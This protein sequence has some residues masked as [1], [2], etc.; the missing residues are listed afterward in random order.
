MFC[1]H[2]N[3]IKLFILQSKSIW[4]S[5]DMCLHCYIKNNNWNIIKLLFYYFDLFECIYCTRHLNIYL[6]FDSLKGKDI[7]FLTPNR[8]F[9]NIQFIPDVK[10]KNF[11]C[12]SILS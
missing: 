9:I 12:V 3:S 10:C 4:L 7:Y 2:H 1:M 8:I 6:L 5:S 11:F